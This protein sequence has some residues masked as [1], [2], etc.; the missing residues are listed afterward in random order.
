MNTPQKP[1][2]LPPSDLLGL[3]WRKATQHKNLGE[4]FITLECLALQVQNCDPSS[5]FVEHDGEIKE[6]S[7]SMI[8]KPNAKLSHEE[9]EIKP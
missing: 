8:V 5:I 1:L 9:G 6:V 3:S 7:R 2:P 4:V